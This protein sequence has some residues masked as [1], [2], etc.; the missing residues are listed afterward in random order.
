M[1][2][3]SCAHTRFPGKNKPELSK[4]VLDSVTEQAK[5]VLNLN[6]ETNKEY[7]KDL[8]KKHSKKYM[9]CN[10]STRTLFVGLDGNV[11]LCRKKKQIGNVIT[12]NIGEVLASEKMRSVK[13][14]MGNCTDTDCLS[15][16]NR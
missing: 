15:Y 1:E 7:I 12:N 14:D 13:R 8:I 2:E 6:I 11:W 3:L 4:K 5:E 9:T 16:D 10:W